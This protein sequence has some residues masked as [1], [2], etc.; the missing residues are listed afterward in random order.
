[1]VVQHLMSAPG[2]SLGM[3]EKTHS[4]TAGAVTMS[5][6]LFSTFGTRSSRWNCY[7]QPISSAHPDLLSGNAFNKLITSG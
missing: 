2:K 7:L 5:G 4:Q 3:E 1:M 6:L